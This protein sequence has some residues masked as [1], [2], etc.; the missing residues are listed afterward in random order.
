MAA[1]LAPILLEHINHFYCDTADFFVQREDGNAQIFLRERCL[2]GGVSHLSDGIFHFL[3]VLSI[4]FNPDLPPIVCI[5]EPELGLHPNI[6]PTV[7]RIMKEVLGSATEC[8]DGMDEGIEGEGLEP[9]TECMD[10]R[11]TKEAPKPVAECT[12]IVTTYSTELV[13][14]FTETPEDVLV[15]DKF[16][17]GT[18]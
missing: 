6:L 4:L 18:Q 1:G 14:S 16:G 11:I 12:M 10:G 9:I 8:S 17:N 13:D 3:A 2:E 15:C 7:G 5:E